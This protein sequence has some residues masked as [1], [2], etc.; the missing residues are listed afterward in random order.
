MLKLAHT[1]AAAVLL[2]LAAAPVAGAHNAGHLVLPGGACVEV[3]S[4]E[5]VFPGPDKTA[6][7]DLIPATL[8]DEIGTSFAAWQGKTP[9]LPGSCLS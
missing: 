6:P 2:A 7:L 5:S 9:L 4:F 1:A 8:P 3:G